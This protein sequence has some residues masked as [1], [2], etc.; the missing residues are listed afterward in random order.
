MPGARGIREAF[1]AARAG[2]GCALVPYITLGHPSLPT[3][4]AVLEAIEELGCDVV[5]VGIPFSDPVAD[6]P[7]IQRSI[8]SALSQGGNLRS[9]LDALNGSTSRIPRLLFSYL[10]PLLKM[11]WP[12]L[13][14]AL[15]K[16]GVRGVL[17]T[18]LV[19][20]EAQEWIPMARSARIETCFLVTPT[21]PE[22]RVRRAIEASSGFVYCVSTLGVTGARAQVDPRARETVE[23]VRAQTDLPVAVG[24]GV[25]S[26]EDVRRIRDYADGVVVGSALVD[27]I[28]DGDDAVQ[29]V[30]RA[31][32]FLEPLLEAAHR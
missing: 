6:G 30:G 11:G 29:A 27:A 5:E 18:D 16:A 24:F 31:Q 26:A 10:N 7:T 3:S 12:P 2:G 32:R 28:G 20:E 4:L 1:E 22:D 17:V 14:H 15:P 9:C 23:R 13:L 25:R 19:P 8:E 21:S